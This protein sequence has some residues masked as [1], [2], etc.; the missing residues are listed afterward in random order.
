VPPERARRLPEQ[1]LAPARVRAQPLAPLA[2]PQE[3]GRLP[4]VLVSLRVQ[5]L[6]QARAQ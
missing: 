2:L 3:L 4:P 6:V 5:A 1:L